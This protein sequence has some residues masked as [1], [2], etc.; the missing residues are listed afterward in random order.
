[1]WDQGRVELGSCGLQDMTG[2][3]HAQ[4]ELVSSVWQVSASMVWPDVCLPMT[5]LG[6]FHVPESMHPPIYMSS[7][8]QIT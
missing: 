8:S 7:S 6:E 2:L 3:S 5:A 4:K 1:M